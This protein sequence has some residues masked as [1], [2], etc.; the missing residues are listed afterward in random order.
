MQET[1]TANVQMTIRRSALFAFGWALVL[2]GVVGLFLP[3][4]PGALLI[5]A[6]GAI[7]S[8]QSAWLQRALEKCRVQARGLKCSFR[9]VRAWVGIR[10]NRFRK[11]PYNSP[12]DSGCA[13]STQC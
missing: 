2:G 4:V 7:L 5:L 12:R 6:G 11:S 8:P 1:S 13:S 9:H 10:P 3:V